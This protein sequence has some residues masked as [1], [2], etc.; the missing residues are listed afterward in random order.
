MP[1]PSSSSCRCAPRCPARAAAAAAAHWREGARA[2]AAAARG[3]E[4]EEKLLLPSRCR[5]LSPAVGSPA[6][7]VPSL[8]L[9]PKGTETAERHPDARPPGA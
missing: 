8:R 7:A 5:P 2:A 6:A 1:L 3:E 4:A 9:A